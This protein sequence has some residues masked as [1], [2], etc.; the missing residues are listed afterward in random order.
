MTRP[1][2]SPLRVIRRAIRASRSETGPSIDDLRVA[3]P[4]KKSSP[5]PSVRYGRGVSPERTLPSGRADDPDRGVHLLQ[6]V[7]DAADR[8]AGPHGRDE[9][10][11]PTLG[12]GPDLGPRRLLVCR[13]VLGVPVLVGLE[14]AR[15]V[16][17]EPG[18]DR[19]VA[20]RRFGLDVCRTEDDLRAVRPRAPA[21][22][23]TACRR[24]RCSDS[25]GAARSRGR[26][27]C[28]PTSVR[29]SSRRAGSPPAPRLDHRPAVQSLHGAAR[30][31]RFERPG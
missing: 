18:R 4:G 30:I 25:L 23:V 1:T 24:R 29:R 19:V 26:G 17:G 21:S 22:Q 31:H 9:V 5:A 20:L 7:A 12:L 28:C 11:D 16:A 15:D 10:A 6:V 2:G 13:R 27:R 8:P 3:V 14:R